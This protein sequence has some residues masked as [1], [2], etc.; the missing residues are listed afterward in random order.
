MEIRDLIRQMMDESGV[1]GRELSRALGK[2]PTFMGAMLSQSNM[3]RL[4][5]FAAIAE[6]LG[7][8]LIVRKEDAEWHLRDYL[9]R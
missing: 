2:S 1:G 5:T 9:D 6:E 4:D 8:D 3:P 7:Y